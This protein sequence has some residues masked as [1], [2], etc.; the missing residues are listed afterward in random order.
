MVFW[1]KIEVAAEPVIGIA[2]ATGYNSTAGDVSLQA[3]L[4]RTIKV[5]AQARTV[6]VPAENR[7]VIV[8]GDNRRAAA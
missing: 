6:V 8:A 1:P 5:E 3:P 2:A 7:T 4:A